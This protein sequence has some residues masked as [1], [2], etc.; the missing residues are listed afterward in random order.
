M[1]EENGKLTVM[2][3]LPKILEN[4]ADKNTKTSVFLRVL[5]PVI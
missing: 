2:Q 3:I 4:I 1:F 5:L